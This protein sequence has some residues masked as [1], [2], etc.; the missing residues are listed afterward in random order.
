MKWALEQGYSVALAKNA[1]IWNKYTILKE[2]IS[3][4]APFSFKSA[5]LYENIRE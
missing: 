5:D 3:F 1:D 4:F 2:K